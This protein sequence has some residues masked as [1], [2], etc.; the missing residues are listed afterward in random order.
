V[1]GEKG[2]DPAISRSHIECNLFI[3]NSNSFVITDSNDIGSK[4]KIQ[5]GYCLCWNV[6]LESGRSE[7]VEG[8]AE[9]TLW[10]AE[11]APA[12]PFMFCY[13]SKCANVLNFFIYSKCVLLLSRSMFSNF[14]FF[15]NWLRRSRGQNWRQMFRVIRQSS[16]RQS[17]SP[18]HSFMQHFSKGTGW[19]NGRL[20]PKRHHT[21]F[22]V[23]HTVHFMAVYLHVSS[24]LYLVSSFKP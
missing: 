22:K 21:F 6:L 8:F 18:M 14:L 23:S 10:Q 17:S 9:I 3:A 24:D 16:K 19:S 13:Y 15:C 1:F 20:L 7:T 4:C 11:F 5:T 2:N 12:R